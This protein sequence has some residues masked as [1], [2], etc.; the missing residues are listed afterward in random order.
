[1]SAEV[2]PVICFICTVLLGYFTEVSYSIVTQVAPSPELPLT[3]DNDVREY[4]YMFEVL[5]LSNI[6]SVSVGETAEF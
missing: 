2:S 3:M 5:S 6:Y 1:M 4:M